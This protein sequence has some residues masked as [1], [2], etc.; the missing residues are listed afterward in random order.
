MNA[1]VHEQPRVCSRPFTKIRR[2]GYGRRNFTTSRRCAHAP[3]RRVH[4]ASREHHSRRARGA[5]ARR[6]A[7]S[8][9]LTHFKIEKT[10]RASLRVQMID[11]SSNLVDAIGH[12]SVRGRVVLTL[13]RAATPLCPSTS[14]Q[15]PTGATPLCASHTLISIK[16]HHTTSTWTLHCSQPVHI[17]FRSTHRT[18]AEL[19]S[20]IA[21]HR[22]AS[23]SLFVVVHALPLASP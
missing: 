18:P 4:A 5:R 11:L 15:R 12:A 16:H 19:P 17:N 13:H 7:S 21:S 6:R 10:W 20:P 8:V 3:A 1:G 23:H 2:Q 9:D 14:T 22:S